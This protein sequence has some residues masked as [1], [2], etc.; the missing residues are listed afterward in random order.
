[1]FHFNTRAWI[2]NVYVIW[3][4]MHM[5][6]HKELEV[7]LMIDRLTE[8]NLKEFVSILYFTLLAHV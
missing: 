8:N 4:A 2:A 3:V 5:N 7:D 1:M 6:H